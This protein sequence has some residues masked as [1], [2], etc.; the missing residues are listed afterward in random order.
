[1][2]ATKIIWLS[3][4]HHPVVK[5][6][7]TSEDSGIGSLDIFKGHTGVLKTLVYDFQQLA[8]LGVHVRGFDIV[9]AE[10]AVFKLT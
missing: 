8:L 3:C 10:K 2:V 7:A 9:D 1:M 5:S 6:K 4:L